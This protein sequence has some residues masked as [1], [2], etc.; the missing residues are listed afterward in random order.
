MSIRDIFTSVFRRRTDTISRQ[1]GF[2]FLGN[3]K[4]SALPFADVVF[5]NMVELITDLYND[6]EIQLKKGDKALFFAFS[7]FFYVYGQQVLNMYYRDGVVVIGHRKEGEGDDAHHSFRIL[8]NDEY[9]KKTDVK[10]IEVVAKDKDEEIYLMVSTTYR[11]SNKSDKQLLDPYLTLIDNVLNGTN[12]IASRL[13]SAVFATPKTPAG[14]SAAT[15]LLKQEKEQLEKEIEKNYGSLDTQSQ[16]CLFSND[17]SFTTI[18]LAGLDNKLQDKI[19]IAAS[20]IA[21]RIKAPANQSSL[22]DA[23]SSKSLSNGT[24]MREGDFNKYQTFERL[25]K[26]TFMEMAE[27]MNMEITY[28]IANKP[29]RQTQQGI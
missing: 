27:D 26:H 19:K 29:Q 28:T 23:N 8:R 7:K 5:F 15:P 2:G 17:L 13:G 14:A 3:L 24:E 11:L 25:F 22:I 18:N 16:I 12:T 21:D 4:L 1:A 10:K 6:V 20:V 9:T